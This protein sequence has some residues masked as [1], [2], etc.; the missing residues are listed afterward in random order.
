MEK[1]TN[2][3]QKQ[4]E[5]KST[6]E[7]GNM[8]KQESFENIEKYKNISKDDAQQSLLGKRN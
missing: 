7:T 3:Q 5:E 4:L 6:V 2:I 8:S 1:G